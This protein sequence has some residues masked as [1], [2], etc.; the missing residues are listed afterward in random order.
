MNLTRI[1]AFTLKN[2]RNM[3]FHN[4][5]YKISLGLTRILAYSFNNSHFLDFLNESY[6]ISFI[7]MQEF[8]FQSFNYSIL[9]NFVD[10]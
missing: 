8:S 6:K 4:E 5:S 1:L 9:H 3:G 10:S 2:S 7:H